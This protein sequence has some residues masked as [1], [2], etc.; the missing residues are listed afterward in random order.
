MLAAS[1][2]LA[3]LTLGYAALCAGS[4]FT[5]CTRCQGSGKR[6]TPA[7]RS[8][9][10]CRPCKGTGL[11]VRLGR[12]L[13]TWWTRTHAHGNRTDPTHTDNPPSRGRH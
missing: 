11:R 9:G 10:R 6:R 1:L 7:D 13:H 5:T 12:R 2:L 3:L 4:P 8:A